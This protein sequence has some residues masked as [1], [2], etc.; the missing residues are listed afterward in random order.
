YLTLE[1]DCQLFALR[2]TD[3]A[4]LALNFDVVLE[5]LLSQACPFGLE[6]RLTRCGRICPALH[7]RAHVDDVPSQRRD[8]TGS[9]NVNDAI[10]PI[11]LDAGD[12]LAHPTERASDA[13]R[14][15]QPRHE[16][17]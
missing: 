8:L 16:S 15:Q 13:S 17:R 6:L 10:A 1:F 12:Q 7:S 14:Q 3:D 2:L 4:L 9:L 11:G 5:F